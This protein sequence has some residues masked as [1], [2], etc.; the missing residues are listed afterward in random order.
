MLRPLYNWVLRLAAG[1]YAVPAL[2]CAAFIEASVPMVPPDTLLAP[3]VLARRERAFVYAAICTVASVLGGC[4]GYTIG[5]FLA[6][7]GMKILVLTGHAGGYASF[8]AMFAKVGLAVI[9]VKGFLPVPY[10]VVNYAAGLAKFDFPIFI[11]ATATVRSAR[12]FLETVLLQHP[13]A[14]AF[15]DKHLTVLVIA[16]VALIIALVVLVDRLGLR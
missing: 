10:M 5:Y 16:A 1:P 6:P 2:A 13:A 11:A 4:V 9:L 12:F 15:V 8:Q 3:M 7:L 14:Q